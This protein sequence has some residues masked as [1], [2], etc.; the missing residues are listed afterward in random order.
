MKIVKLK[1]ENFKKLSAVEINPEGNTVLITG[2]NGAGKSS[3][4]DAIVAALGG[5][6][7]TPEKPIRDGQERAEVV[8]SLPQFVVRRIFTQKGSRLEITNADGFKADSPQTLLDNLLGEISF[9]PMEFV[10]MGRTAAGKRDRRRILMEMLHLDFSD[11][12]AQIEAIKQKR[13]EAKRDRERFEI[14]LEKTPFTEGLPETEINSSDLMSRLQQAMDQNANLNQLRISL[15]S[16]QQQIL[17]YD[18][19]IAMQKNRIEQAE[20]QLADMRA[21]LQKS[22]EKRDDIVRQAEKCRT[23]IETFDLIDINEVKNSIA[24]VE[25]TNKKIRDNCQ[26][27]TLE[28][29]VEQKKSEFSLLG[30]QIEELEREKAKRLSAAKFP[31]NGL[32]VSEDDILL[33]GIPLDQVNDAKKLEVGIAISM[34]LNPKLKV[35]LMKG[36]DLDSE[37]MR[38]I[39]RMAKD[40]DYQLWIEKVDESGKV[41]IYI[42][43][44][45]IAEHGALLPS[46]EPASAEQ[47]TDESPT[48]PLADDPEAGSFFDD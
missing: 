32:S 35:I 5:K 16:F 44:G 37:S 19:R 31:V 17:S 46:S 30:K 47:S 1:A 33:D 6:T 9:D 40:N 39:S 7:K 14:E 34:A 36:N 22:V 10:N 13:S 4:L 20:K 43:D 25:E 48:V 45:H 18:D 11:I 26:R 15:Q 28:K 38:A 24:S 12:N 41:G 8:V 3:V 42:E 21:E 23:A 27:K 29:F 2:K